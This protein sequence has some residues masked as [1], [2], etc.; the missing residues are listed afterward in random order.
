MDQAKLTNQ[1]LEGG[2]RSIVAGG[3]TQPIEV[4]IQTKDGLKEEDKRLVESLGGKVKDNLY[5]INAFS[6]DISPKSIQMLILSDRIVRI[7]ADSVI[8]S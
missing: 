5:I 4:I 6:A 7:F 1:K 2:L 8:H 3:S